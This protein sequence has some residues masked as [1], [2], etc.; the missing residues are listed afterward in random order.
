[1]KEIIY[2][3]FTLKGIILTISLIVL[4]IFSDQVKT[5]FLNYTGINN[6]NTMTNMGSISFK[7]RFLIKIFISIVLTLINSIALKKGLLDVLLNY[8]LD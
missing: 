4:Y 7:T 5:N 2:K 8:K 1:M 6:I 3:I